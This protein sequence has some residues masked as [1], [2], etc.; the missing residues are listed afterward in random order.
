MLDQVN[1]SEGGVVVLNDG[2]TFGTTSGQ[3]KLHRDR[4]LVGVRV[5][6]GTVEYGNAGS[7]RC[8]WVPMDQIS[9]VQYNV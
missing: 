7:T 5:P 3:I 8:S 4:V 9:E 2:N 6:F 1:V